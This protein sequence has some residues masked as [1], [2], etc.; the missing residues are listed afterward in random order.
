MVEND[1]LFCARGLN[2]NKSTVVRKQP[3]IVFLYLKYK[4]EVGKDRHHTYL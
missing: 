4:P 3:K 1:H 2:F